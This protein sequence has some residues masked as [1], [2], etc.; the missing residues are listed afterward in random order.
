[1]DYFDNKDKNYCLKKRTRKYFFN[2]QINII[3]II[4]ITT[5]ISGSIPYCS[6]IIAKDYIV[7]INNT[8]ISTK[9]FNLFTLL[10]YNSIK[11]STSK[12]LTNRDFNKVQIDTIKYL[13][14]DEILYQQ[15]KLYG[16]IVTNKELRTNL[17]NFEI[18]KNNNVFDKKKYYSF[19]KHIRMSPKEYET[20]IKKQIYKNK[21][22]III[23]YSIKLW[24][25]ELNNFSK[26]N[27]EMTEKTIMKKKIDTITNNW[28]LDTLK[29][30][31]IKI[32]NNKINMSSKNLIDILLKT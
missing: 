31:K 9:I 1:M 20:M 26:Q 27:H 23:T 30:Y 15:S 29:K 10:H 19:L 24:N 7:K 32:N 21:L 18:F 12:Q 6:H 22:K 25:Y 28:Y 14:E 17:R 8:K 13:I 11:K 4:T 5:F 16:I 2:K 3:L